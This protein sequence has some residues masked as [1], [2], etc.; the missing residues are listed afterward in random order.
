MTMHAEPTRP[1]VVVITCHDLGRFLGCY[2]I[3][4]VSSPR[5][6]DLAAD[7]V[8]FE[9]AFCAAPQCGP[10]R[11]ALFSGRYAQSASY[12][13]VGGEGPAVM[14]WGLADGERH[15]ASELADAG[16][17]C[18][19]VGCVHESFPSD[20]L[21]LHDTPDVEGNVLAAV[22]IEQLEG[23]AADQ[24]P[25]YLQVGFTEPHR[26]YGERDEPRGWGFLGNH[27]EPDDEL[28]VTVPEYLLDD[29]GS[30]AEFAELQGAVRYV[31]ASIG[32]IVDRLHDLALDENTLVLLA[33]DHGLSM[34]RAKMSLYDPGLEVALIARYPRRGWA[35]GR[36]IGEL[37]S[38][39]DI[40]PTVMDVVGLP[41]SD[42]VQGRSLTPLL[43][44]DP[45]E[46]RTEVFAQQTYHCYYDPRRCIRTARH[47]LIVNFSVGYAYMVEPVWRQRST[48]VAPWWP[49]QGPVQLYDLQIDP[50]ELNN[51]ADDPMYSELRR[52]LLVR[53]HQ[54]MLDTKDP[55]LDGAVMSPRHTNGIRALEQSRVG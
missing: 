49:P 45:Y 10:S 53:L 31:D 7:G 20:L 43:D 1:N 9:H 41:T 40:F 18:V 4:T 5:I 2:G 11:A 6:D 17:T 32:R 55:I 19:A 16:W 21:V 54:W 23:F 37:V 50:L 46:G 29:E 8:R 47:K 26:I 14:G 24:R 36:V 42:R 27:V 52:G 15:I 3:P 38:N 25:F 22:A 35:G 33:A 28:G 39:V 12:G 13:V 30:R 44:G 34:P 51:L 48:P